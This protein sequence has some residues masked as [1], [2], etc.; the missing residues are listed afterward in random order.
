MLLRDV[1]VASASVSTAWSDEE[2]ARLALPYGVSQEAMLRRLESLG[3]TSWEYYIGRRSHFLEAYEE[4]R[5]R[6]KEK[7]GGGLTY[8]PKKV[9]DFGRR[10][11]GTVLDAYYRSDITGSELSDYLRIKINQVPQL[12]TTL[13]GQQ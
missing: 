13:E 2:L 5:R 10:Y 6:Q 12:E 8:Y 7:Q 1:R 11:V 3:R 4:A 9:R